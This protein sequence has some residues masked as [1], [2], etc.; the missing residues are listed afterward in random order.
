MNRRF[1]LYLDGMRALAALVVLLSHWAYDRYTGGTY[2]AIRDLNLGS[3][4]VVIF[5]VLSG[6]V[7]GFTAQ[8]KDDTL[9]SFLF[10]RAT[11]LYSVAVP[12]V[13]LTILL[14][15]VGLLFRPEAYDGFWYN[16]A[17]V[18]ETAAY[19]LS[20]AN[21]WALGAFR[22][23]SNG[24][25]WSL[26]YEVAYYLL[27]AAVCYLKGGLRYLV[28]LLLALIFGLNILLLLP[29]WLMG[30]LLWRYLSRSPAPLAMPV[31]LMLTLVPVVLYCAAL[32]ADLPG[33][34]K[35]A[36][37]DILGLDPIRLSAAL[38]FSDEVVWNSCLGF[39]T[40]LHLLGI[41]SL[42]ANVAGMKK[43]SEVERRIRWA[44]G[45]SFSLYLVHYPVLQ[46][47][48]AM[49]DDTV[50]P[51]LWDWLLLTLTLIICFL[52]AQVFERPLKPFRDWVRS[53]AAKNP[54]KPA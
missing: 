12:A 14:D 21:E 16:D 6:F 38:R 1:S 10:A 45:G 4:A 7:I 18:L 17:G 48:D 46:F 39:L 53:V 20:F 25:W 22:V 30:L 29:T 33:I 5:F 8:T 28:P 26:S 40:T 52:F 31:A 36:T 19:G 27:F 51:A 15:R 32:A 47:F 11:R 23:G 42:C 13:L 24:P 37:S 43:G 54:L 35:V 34:L 44:A 41:H 2:S 3:D 50:P 49:L 9:G